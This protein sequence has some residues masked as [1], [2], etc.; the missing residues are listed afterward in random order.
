MIFMNTKKTISFILVFAM[1]FSI[2]TSYPFSVSAINPTKLYKFDGNTKEDFTQIAAKTTGSVAYLDGKNNQAIKFSN[3]AFMPMSSTPHNTSFSYAVWINIE[4]YTGTPSILGNQ[5]FDDEERYGWS[6]SLSGPG[7]LVHSIGTGSGSQTGSFA[8]NTWVHY[9]FTFNRTTGLITYYLDGEA[10]SSCTLTSGEIQKL[11]SSLA[12]YAGGNATAPSSNGSATVLMDDLSYFNTELT[13]AQI[14]EIYN[15]EPIDA[16]PD[17]QPSLFKFDKNLRDSVLDTFWPITSDLPPV[18]V[19]GQRDKAVKLDGVSLDLGELNYSKNHTIGAWMKLNSYDGNAVIMGNKDFSSPNSPGWALY[20]EKTTQTLYFKVSAVNSSENIS[21]PITV[22]PVGRWVH[23]AYSFNRTNGEIT[24]YVNGSPAG[25]VLN[26]S[27]TVAKSIQSAFS[28]KLGS[29]GTGAYTDKANIEFDNL[30]IEPSLMNQTSVTARIN[31]E[32]NT[33]LQFENDLTNQMGYVTGFMIGDVSYTPNGKFDNALI[34]TTSSGNSSY[35][36][37]ATNQTLE[38]SQSFSAS[39]WIKSNETAANTPILGNKSDCTSSGTGWMFSYDSDGNVCFKV[40]DSV[41]TIVGKPSDENYS[42]VGMTFDRASGNVRLFFDGV[43]VTQL[44]T[45]ITSET[46]INTANTYIGRI[47]ASTITGGVSTF[48]IDELYI[49]PRLYSDDEIIDLAN[50]SSANNSLSFEWVAGTTASQNS[51]YTVDLHLTAPQNARIYDSVSFMLSYDQSAYALSSVEAS[52]LTALDGTDGAKVF[53]AGL[54]RS[55][56]GLSASPGTTRL[57]RFTFEVKAVTGE[58]PITVTPTALISNSF[59]MLSSHAISAPSLDTVILSPGNNDIN[60]DGVIGIGDVVLAN[61]ANKNAVAALSDIYPYKRALVLTLGGGGTAFAPNAFTNSGATLE[62][63]RVNPYSLDLFN[64]KSAVSYSAKAVDPTFSA[65]NYGAILHGY[66]YGNVSYEYKLDALS[67]ANTYFYKNGADM[68]SVLKALKDLFPA[69][70]QFAITTWSNIANGIIEPNL[71]IGIKSTLSDSQNVSELV[72]YINSNKMKNTAVTYAQWDNMNLVGQSTGYNNPAWWEALSSYDSYYQNV[73]DA[74]SQSGCGDD[75]FVILNSDHGGLGSNNGGTSAEERNIMIAL[76][77]TTVDS[78][79]VLNGGTSADIPAVLLS[80]LR[81]DSVKPGSMYE[82]NVFD[83]NAFLSQKQLGGKNRDVE[84]VTLKKTI[85]DMS[86]VIDNIQSGHNIVAAEMVLNLPNNITGLTLTPASGLTVYKQSFQNGKLHIIVSG[87]AP[88]TGGQKILS[89]TYDGY[90]R[91][92]NMV[93][94]VM[95]GTQTG[96]EIYCDLFEESIDPQTIT[97][98]YFD[99]NEDI[100]LNFETS[101]ELYIGESYEKTAPDFYAYVY[102]GYSVDFG[103]VIKEHPSFTVFDNH[104][105]IYYYKPD[106]NGNN[107]PDDEEVFTVTEKYQFVDGELVSGDTS[108]KIIGWGSVFLK[109]LPPNYGLLYLGYSTDEYGFQEGDPYFEVYDDM[110]VIYVYTLDINNNGIAD[111]E[112]AFVITEKYELADG[113]P[114]E[115]DTFYDIMGL[116]TEYMGYPLDIIGYMYIG[117]TVNGSILTDGIPSFSVSDNDVVVYVYTLDENNNG[118]PDNKEIY[119]INQIF[120]LEDDTEISGSI[121]CEIIGR[122]SLYEYT[123]PEIDGYV[124]VGYRLDWGEIIEGALG[125]EVYEDHDIIFVYAELRE[126]TDIIAPR[127][128]YCFDPSDI[129]LP[130]Y[131]EVI[132]ADGSI[133]YS[134]VSWDIIDMVAYGTLNEDFLSE[135]LLYNPNNLTIQVDIFI[136]TPIIF[137]TDW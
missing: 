17:M 45:L 107:K 114:V 68:P 20:L 69:R 118:I 1:L 127:P 53:R 108:E 22:L 126:I 5:E 117:Y 10:T 95:L 92:D 89:L 21:A 125:F 43:F 77:G 135:N 100:P 128:F 29:D 35:V 119:E 14:Y 7:T 38:Y 133:T 3:G 9:A 70:S 36:S 104:S 132:L 111:D 81:L 26:A 98:Q 79:R 82:S 110:T 93:H 57:A 13:E 28:T 37:I 8:L 63:N 12:T 121:L 137:P 129:D 88:L 84:A 91:G 2:L 33:Y 62:G 115:S 101:E 71:G 102:Y 60:K 48:C 76:N 25:T 65:P 44:E 72:S 130:G 112:E 6:L 99:Y 46:T 97:E 58:K 64:N 34:I 42:H 80:A 18:F 73:M 103:T 52:A 94:E 59:D 116:Y 47:N 19:N 16:L 106:L 23:L 136:Y 15:P 4:S 87:T 85:Y 49:N 120:M 134:A 83:T 30:F 54:N 67:T 31:K 40:N 24:F 39:F 56:Y 32:T 75:T 11:Q 41:L 123:P 122:G 86:F 50:A 131:A 66:S 96:D 124:Y 27:N 55:L 105:V 61:G 74:L 78:G 90:D 113:T 51:F 109:I